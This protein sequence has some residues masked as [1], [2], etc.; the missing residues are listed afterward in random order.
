MIRYLTAI[1][2]GLV[3]ALPA[4]GQQYARPAVP[5]GAD[6]NDWEAYFDLGV[7][8]LR[9]DVQSA[10]AAFYWASRLNP[11]RAE[12]LFARW[13]TFH[14]QDN[15]RFGRYVEGN[16]KVLADPD[17]QAADSLA[18]LAFARNPFVYRSLEVA[19]YDLTG[20]WGEDDVSLGWAYYAEPDPARAVRFFGRALNADPAGWMWLRPM[21][22]QAFVALGRPDSALAEMEQLRK[23]LAASTGRKRRR[24]LVYDSQ[25]FLKY[26]EAMLLGAMRRSDS[27]RVM[28]QQ[29]IVEDAAFWPAHLYL[30]TE[31]VQR[32]RLGDAQMEFDQAALVAPDDPVVL[33]QRA[34]F[35]LRSGQLAASKADAM[36]AVELEPYWAAALTLLGQIAEKTGDATQAS[37]AFSA[38]L[39]HGA[40]ND[41]ARA[42]AEQALARLGVRR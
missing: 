3:V 15:R 8:L 9:Q 31:A 10:T 23:S 24:S 38:A 39:Q 33:L 32:G 41:P 40:R 6:S 2:L 4:T 36:H 5:K 13:V 37:A 11:E 29:A 35:L 27:A 1:A 25:A 12:P 30:A 7:T 26:A 20:G 22:A 34:R 17:V 16:A 18:R 28:M 19:L 42:T 14:M 21:R